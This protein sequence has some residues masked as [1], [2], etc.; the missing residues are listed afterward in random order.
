MPRPWHQRAHRHMRHSL[1]ARLVLLFL[2]LAL[3]LAGAF[4]FGMQQ[5]LGIGWRDAARPLVTD[6]VDRL[7]AEV[8]SPPS[9]E[10]A[11]ALAQR[12]PITVRIHGPQVNW[13]SHAT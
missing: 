3:A 8:G 1:K 9:V 2:L 12:L 11:Q 10:R 5:A 6:Y 7:A 13:E 4:L